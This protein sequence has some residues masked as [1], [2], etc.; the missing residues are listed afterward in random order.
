MRTVAVVSDRVRHEG[1]LHARPASSNP[2]S[3][4]NQVQ[5]GSRPKILLFNFQNGENHEGTRT[6]ISTI[7]SA[8]HPCY[9]HFRTIPDGMPDRVALR[10][11]QHSP[12]PFTTLDELRNLSLIKFPESPSP[13]IQRH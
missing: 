13:Q 8:L 6:V 1:R 2:L 3:C 7:E 9:S 11:R 10:Q 4:A 5:Y 12:A